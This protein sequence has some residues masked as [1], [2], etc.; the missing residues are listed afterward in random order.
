[1]PHAKPP[2][3]DIAYREE[4]IRCKLTVFVGFR[5]MNE[6]L[7]PGGG[8]GSQAVIGG[9]EIS[10]RCRIQDRNL[11]DAGGLFEHG[12]TQPV[13]RPRRDPTAKDMSFNY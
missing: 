9:V 8:A 11:P 13:T 5:K 6:G 12:L 10:E 1:M 3:R 2:L 4:P 7:F